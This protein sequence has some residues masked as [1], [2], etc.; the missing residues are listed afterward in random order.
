MKEIL[1]NVVWIVL[2]NMFGR[3]FFVKIKGRIIVFEWK[4]KLKMK[5]VNLVRFVSIY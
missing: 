2:Y 4:K 5:N 3:V 1:I